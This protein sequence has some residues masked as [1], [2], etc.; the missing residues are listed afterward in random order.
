MMIVRY[1][2]A[3]GRVRSFHMPHSGD[4]LDAFILGIEPGRGELA[5]LLPITTTDASEVQ[6]VLNLVTG[7]TQDD[8]HAIVDS[9]GNVIGAT[10]ADPI[11]GDFVDG[12]R[13]IPKS[14]ANAFIG[15]TFDDV[16]G[17]TAKSQPAI[18]PPKTD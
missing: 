10:T 14:N 13:L 7:K 6:R 3:T 8:M 15:G 12:C 4:D 11:C 17:F 16:N 18:G 5:Q 9:S 2:A 1:S